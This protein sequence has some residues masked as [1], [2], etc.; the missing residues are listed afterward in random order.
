MPGEKGIPPARGGLLT[1]KEQLIWTQRIELEEGVNT[2]VNPEGY[3]VHGAIRTL[4]VPKR[5]KPGHVDPTKTRND[6]G[7]PEGSKLK[8]SLDFCLAERD[9]PRRDRFLWPD[10]AY[11]EHGWFQKDPA[12]GPE[13]R[14][15]TTLTGAMPIHN[16]IGWRD[17]RYE[18]K[19]YKKIAP[20]GLFSLSAANDKEYVEKPPPPRVGGPADR[21]PYAFVSRE[22]LAK[23]VADR[24][25][26]EQ[27]TVR[28]NMHCGADRRANSLG[29]IGTAT[30]PTDKAPSTP[31]GGR[32]LAA[33]RAISE[34]TLHKFSKP[35]MVA[36]DHLCTE[37]FD[38]AL[39]RQR[40][41]MNRQPQYKWY[42]PLTQNP[43]T[44]YVDHFTKSF[45]K[46]YFGKSAKTR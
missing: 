10:T 13:K 3:S 17:K 11:Q 32:V 21:A 1:S 5:F 25:A 16:G 4:D 29:V 31:S 41:F 20:E 26:R 38:D 28:G 19:V 43:I 35:Q 36:D 23:V 34:G 30:D 2:K 22:A 6:E 18:E 24:K 14:D 44:T 8:K 9:A 46:P 40:I 12:R 27:G 39:A 45:G 37:S 33:S 15:R 7:F 42:V